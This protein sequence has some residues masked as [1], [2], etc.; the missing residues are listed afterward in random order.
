LALGRWDDA[1]RSTSLGLRRGAIDA[2]ALWLQVNRARL[3]IARGHFSEAAVLLRRARA[4]DER[5]GAGE[6]RTALL[7]AEAE[8][9]VWSGQPAEA[10][11]LGEAGLSSLAG[12]APPDPSLAWLGGVVRRAVADIGA[13]V[14]MGGAHESGGEATRGRPLAERIEAAIEEVRKRPGF[15]TGERVGALLALL[16]AEGERVAG[17]SNPDAWARVFE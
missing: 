16:E 17:R 3:L 14:P 2:G 11:P 4:I 8:L 12:G 7:A 9:A 5:L 10:L 15:S 13:G 6:Y 1:E